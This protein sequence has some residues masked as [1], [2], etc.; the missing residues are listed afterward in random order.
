MQQ[1]LVTLLAERLLDGLT[2]LCV[3][4][5]VLPPFFGATG[6][7]AV[8][9]GLSAPG[10]GAL[11][12]LGAGSAFGLIALAIVARVRWAALQWLIANQLHSLRVDALAIVQRS[13]GH[14]AFVA[15]MTAAGW[16]A[17]F[18]MHY[19]VLQALDPPDALVG[20]LLLAVVV[21]LSTNL[22]MLA[23]ATPGGIGLFHAAAAAPLLVAGFSSEVAVAYALLVH[24]M[25]TVPP[26]LVGAAGLGGPVLAARLRG[27]PPD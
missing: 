25:N 27:E 11:I 10:T 15:A 6:R 9:D 18:L 2:L 4:L 8:V 24:V 7:Q 21:V 19:A 26:M 3:A 20:P 22:S 1:A 5:V 23:P 14:F 16:A 12:L 17:T 13:P